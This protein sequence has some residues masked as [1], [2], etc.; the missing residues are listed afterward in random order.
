MRSI[1][2]A[3]ERNAVDVSLSSSA[4]RRTSSAAASGPGR[5]PERFA[6]ASRTIALMRSF[7]APARGS[8]E[9]VIGCGL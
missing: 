1:S 8:T 4:A 6:A 9:P 2:S 7:A 5:A 3:L